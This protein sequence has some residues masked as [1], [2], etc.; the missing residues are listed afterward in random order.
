MGFKGT[1]LKYRSDLELVVF[2]H[3]YKGHNAAVTSDGTTVSVGTMPVKV[4]GVLGDTRVR[5]PL[6]RRRDF[7]LEDPDSLAGIQTYLEEM[8][9]CC[10]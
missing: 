2:F 1:I 6:H 7:D 3:N 4:H 5:S 10:S 8:L 9:E